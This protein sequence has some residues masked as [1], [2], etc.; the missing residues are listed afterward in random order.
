MKASR[1][2]IEISSPEHRERHQRGDGAA[3]DPAEDDRE[4]AG[5]FVFLPTLPKAGGSIP[6]SDI[7]MKIRVCP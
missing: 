5:V 1:V 4:R 6:S 2:P 7:R 3:D